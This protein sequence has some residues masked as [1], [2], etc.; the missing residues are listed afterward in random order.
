[1]LLAPRLRLAVRDLTVE[2]RTWASNMEQMVQVY[3]FGAATPACASSHPD[4]VVFTEGFEDPDD[5]ARRHR[6]PAHASSS[7]TA[8]M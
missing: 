3:G 4:Q 8:R 7:R 6:W 2:D 5:R 1:M